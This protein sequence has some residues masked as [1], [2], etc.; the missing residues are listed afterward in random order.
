[1]EFKVEKGAYEKKIEDEDS[2]FKEVY[3]AKSAGGNSGVN[4]GY[5]EA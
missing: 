5:E 4:Q 1:M 2:E 3:E